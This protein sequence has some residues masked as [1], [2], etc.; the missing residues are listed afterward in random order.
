MK[1]II[2]D[3]QNISIY[4]NDISIYSIYIFYIYR[5]VV[6]DC[7]CLVQIVDS[8]FLFCVEGTRNN[9]Y[10]SVNCLYYVL[11]HCSRDLFRQSVDIIW[12]CQ[13]Y[14]CVNL[15]GCL[16]LLTGLIFFKRTFWVA[17]VSE[18]CLHMCFF[19]L[20]VLVFGDDCVYP[21]V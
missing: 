4:S 18:S 20:F 10:G 12:Y 13:S 5:F 14:N 16:V 17:A 21:D 1:K 15:L 7:T 11:L 19:C 2:Q 9:L 8:V 6:L 3:P